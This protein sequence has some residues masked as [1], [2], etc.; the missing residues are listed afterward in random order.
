MLLVRGGVEGVEGVEGIESCVVMET[1][2]LNSLA[3][4]SSCRV[5]WF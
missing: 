2:V 4:G 1:T 5:R 3:V